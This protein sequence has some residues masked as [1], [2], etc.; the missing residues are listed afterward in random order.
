MNIQYLIIRKILEGKSIRQLKIIL[1]LM[2]FLN[3]QKTLWYT[4]IVIRL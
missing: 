3:V 4:D 1:F 2:I